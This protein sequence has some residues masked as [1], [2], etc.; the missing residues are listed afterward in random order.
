M[1]FGCSSNRQRNYA[2]WRRPFWFY[3]SW[4]LQPFYIVH[5]ALCY[6]FNFNSRRDSSLSLLLLQYSPLDL[7]T[8][9]MPNT[10]WTW[11]NRNEMNIICLCKYLREDESS[12]DC[13]SNIQRWVQISNIVQVW[14]KHI[15]ITRRWQSS[16]G[17]NVKII[18]V[19][20][21]EKNPIHQDRD[22]CHLI[23][24]LSHFDHVTIL[25]FTIQKPLRMFS[26]L[27]RPRT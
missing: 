25:L 17:G 5:C 1:T 26:L 13:W 7:W 14:W 27:I 21:I 2:F 22:H 10:R 6:L 4:I 12:I 15:W 19:V 9:R 8:F 3:L 11:A 24:C 20:K 23:F 16:V 18:I